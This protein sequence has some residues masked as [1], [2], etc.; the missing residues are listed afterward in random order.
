MCFEI[1]VLRL[2]SLVGTSATNT[3]QVK[4]KLSGYNYDEVVQVVE[5]LT[6]LFGLAVVLENKASAFNPSQK[7]QALGTDRR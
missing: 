5:C 1:F 2:E 7:T 4:E 6:N 3:I